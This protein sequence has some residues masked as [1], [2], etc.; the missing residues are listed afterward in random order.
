M[1]LSDERRNFWYSE[2]NL[3]Y[4]S[5]FNLLMNFWIFFFLSGSYFRQKWQYRK[6]LRSSDRGIDYEQLKTN[7]AWIGPTVRLNPY[8]EWSKYKFFRN[9]LS[10]FFFAIKVLDDGYTTSKSPMI[11]SWVESL[12]RNHFRKFSILFLDPGCGPAPAKLKACFSTL[13]TSWAASF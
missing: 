11:E 4:H 3:R 12:K 7:W 1:L 6:F 9:Q 8:E 10:I 5:L 13:L 2:N